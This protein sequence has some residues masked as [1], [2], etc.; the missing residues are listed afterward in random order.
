MGDQS[1]GHLHRHQ[2][3][4]LGDHHGGRFLVA[5]YG[6]HGELSI[7]DGWHQY[8]A[9]LH[10]FGDL[11]RII[12]LLGLELSQFRDGRTQRSLQVIVVNVLELNSS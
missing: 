3:L 8:P 9:R 12:L 4:R 7:S 6:P 5:L 1:T 10:R 2:N 11:F